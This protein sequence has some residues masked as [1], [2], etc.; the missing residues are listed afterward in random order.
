MKVHFLFHFFRGYWY[1]GAQSVFEEFFLDFSRILR[2]IS[3]TSKNGTK[4]FK[5]RSFSP[6]FYLNL[7]LFYLKHF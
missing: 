3:H 1:L 2:I 7:F 4:N 5:Q 6:S